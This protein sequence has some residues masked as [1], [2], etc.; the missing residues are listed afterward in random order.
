MTRSWDILHTAIKEIRG[1]DRSAQTKSW[2]SAVASEINRNA[3]LGGLG[4]ELGQGGAGLYE[5]MGIG[6]R[7]E[8]LQ[9]VM[10]SRVG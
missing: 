7:G 10:T 4:L 1:L 3:L 2:T 9:G 5:G 8:F 6:Q